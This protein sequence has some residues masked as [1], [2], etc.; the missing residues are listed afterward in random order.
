MKTWELEPSGW[1]WL[2]PLQSFIISQRAAPIWGE[3]P[4][5]RTHSC[6]FVR[7][8]YDSV[9]HLFPQSRFYQLVLV[10]KLVTLQPKRPFLWPVATWCLLM[11]PF[12]S[13]KKDTITTEFVEIRFSLTHQS[14]IIPFSPASQCSSQN[15]V[16]FKFY[17]QVIRGRYSVVNM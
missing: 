13:T 1:T 17:H 15:A 6:Q 3:V 16:A 9:T 11:T 12:S 14:L 10:V 5:L 4:R 2:R 8:K 7:R